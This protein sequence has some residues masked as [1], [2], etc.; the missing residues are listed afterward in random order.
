MTNKQKILKGIKLLT[1]FIFC[2]IVCLPAPVLGAEKTI[3]VPIEKNYSACTFKVVCEE[4]GDYTINLFSPNGTIYDFASIDDLTY[5][6]TVKNVRAGEWMILTS[7]PNLSSIG[8]VIVSVN[9]AKTEDG[10]I[11]DDIVVGKDIVGLD[12]YLKNNLVVA[13]WTDENCGAVSFRIVNLDTSELIAN[14]KSQNKY[15]ECEIPNDTIN[16]SVDVTP[17]SSN[18]ITG[19]TSKYTFEKTSIEGTITYPETYYVNTDEIEIFVSIPKDY[20]Y[21]VEIN[22]EEV[23]SSEYLGAGEHSIKI[24]LLTEGENIIQF[25]LV[26]EDGNMQSTDKTYF[27]D[28]VAP[29]ITLASEYDGMEIESETTVIEGVIKDFS[30]F[31]IND[32]PVDVTS[33]GTFTYE[34]LLHTGNNLITLVAKDDAGNEAVYNINFFVPEETNGISPYVL[35]VIAVVI[36]FFVFKKNKTVAIP[37]K[38]SEESENIPVAH[39]NSEIKEKIGISEDFVEDDDK[40]ANLGEINASGDDSLDEM[41]KTENINIKKSDLLKNL[42]NNKTYISYIIYVVALVV[43]FQFILGLAHISSGSMEPTIMTNDLMVYNRLAYFQKE[44]TYGD[45]ISFKKNG[46][47]YCKR[48]VGLAG[49]EIEF[50]DGFIYR[51][52]ERVEEYYIESDIETNCIKTF[53]VPDNC[54]F[55]LGDNRENSLDSRYWENPYINTNDINGKLLF[56]VPLS[57]LL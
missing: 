22:G 28:V 49:D 50:H 53:T 51:N 39:L 7:E 9:A 33:D 48:I 29:S 10:N 2:F 3:N 18:N 45:I 14:E 4:E 32:M 6:C 31:T 11:K 5:T 25:F 13:T 12:I 21:L 43:L 46:E 40:N 16:F 37:T 30:S 26:N 54:I 24:P 41:N 57:D 44:P 38:D 19:A 27:K 42:K 35:L 20:G 17:S 52:G 8:K 36:L 1:F 15:F 34:C 23:S 55:V 47:D 56:V